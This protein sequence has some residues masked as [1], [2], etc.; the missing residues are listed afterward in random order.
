M[1][2]SIK[3][4]A[5]AQTQALKK[6]NYW[7]GVGDV[8]KGPTS[9]SD[10]WSAIAPPTNGYTIYQNKASNGP[11][12]NVAANDAGLYRITNKIA[13]TN[14]ST[15]TDCLNWF[16]TQSD[17]MVLDRDYEAIV[18]TDL[19]L[20]LDAGFA[21]SYPRNGT[22]WY[23]VSPAAKSATLINGPVYSLY[24]GLTGVLGFDGVDDY[25]DVDVSHITAATITVSGFM[26][27]AQFTS[28]MF[29]G[30]TAYDVWT[31]GNS[32]GFNTGNGDVYGIS[33]GQVSSLQLLGNYAHYAFVMTA[34]A[35]IPSTNKIYIN[36]NLQTLSQQYSST[37]SAPGFGSTMRIS[38]W[39]NSTNYT[40]HID[41]GTF[42]IHNRE[43]TINEIK[44]NYNA[45][46]AR[47]GL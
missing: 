23:D 32:L 31:Q 6:S 33:A 30:F 25:A 43:L 37:G 22:T 9:T 38:G 39:L 34:N 28:G 13:G 17:K 11:S 26:R 4:S 41:Y 40:N 24:N 27:W 15:V 44:Q 16:N 18:T 45:Q 29:F 36:G 19:I 2:N 10:Y 1:A 8:A 35:N 7:I 3:Y 14:Y 12:I 20:N 42:Q 46:K 5:S 47:Y 21:P